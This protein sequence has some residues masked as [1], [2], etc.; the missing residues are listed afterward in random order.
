[1]QAKNNE[2]IIFKP[3]IREYHVII[4]GDKISS[5]VYKGFL[6]LV[7]ICASRESSSVVAEL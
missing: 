7:H 2:M 6:A 3:S 4:G 5:K 1:M